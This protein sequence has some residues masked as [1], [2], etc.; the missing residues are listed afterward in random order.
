MIRVLIADDRA[1]VLGAWAA[2]LGLEPD[3][4]VVGRAANGREALA[5]C[6]SLAPDIVLTDIERPQMTGLERAGALAAQ[7]L[8][9]M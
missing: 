9:C 4:A 8:P 6:V 5:M 7:R 1:L 3:V 2:L